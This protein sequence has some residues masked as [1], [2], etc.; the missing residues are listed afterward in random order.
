MIL[1]GSNYRPT[2]IYWESQLNDISDNEWY[3]IKVE[4]YQGKFYKIRFRSKA[5]DDTYNHYSVLIEKKIN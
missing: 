4:K 2:N 3:S 1:E 5:E